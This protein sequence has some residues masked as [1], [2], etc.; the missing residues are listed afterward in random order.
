MRADI[1]ACD[2]CGD[3]CKRSPCLVG[4]PAE[5]AAIS[6]FVG[7]DVRHGL[8]IEGTPS[9]DVVVRISKEKPCRFFNG[10]CSIQPVKPKGGADYECWNPETFPLRYGWSA[11]QLNEASIRLRAA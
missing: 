4:S 3:C 8:S 11:D 5:L 7:F 9:G 1:S 6:Q 10:R 2:H